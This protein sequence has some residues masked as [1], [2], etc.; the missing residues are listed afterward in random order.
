MDNTTLL[1]IATLAL[2]PA[3]LLIFHALA[4]RLVKTRSNQ[5]L[6]LAC[7]V[8][9]NLP[10]FAAL[11]WLLGEKLDVASVVYALLVYNGAGYFYFH[12]FNMSETARRVKLVVGIR[13]GNVRKLQDVQG[14]YDYHNTLAVRL[15]RLEA[16]GEVAR[17]ANGVFRLRRKAPLYAAA[18]VIHALR[19]LLGFR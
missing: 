15:E 4:A 3:G 19:S 7:I 2:S 6:A 18:C 11:A 13:K 9:F 16:L 10:L 14:H 5:K 8:T 1:Y 12:F 17:D